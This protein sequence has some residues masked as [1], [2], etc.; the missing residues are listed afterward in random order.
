M[1][2]P[3]RPDPRPVLRAHVRL[4]VFVV[5]GPDG[6]PIDDDEYGMLVGSREKM[7]TIR[8]DD[9]LVEA[10]L[11]F[12]PLTQESVRARRRGKK[13][14]GRKIGQTLTEYRRESH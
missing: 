13:H 10:V 1:S 4:R 2:N 3:N 9:R 12:V 5:V 7:E 8:P 6:H 14:P 11:A